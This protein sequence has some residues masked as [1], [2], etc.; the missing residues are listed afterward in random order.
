MDLE[1]QTLYDYLSHRYQILLPEF[2]SCSIEFL[3][4]IESGEKKALLLIATR[5]FYLPNV[6]FAPTKATD[7]HK[8]CVSNPLLKEYIQEN[9]I[10]NREFL[11]KIIA[12]LELETLLELNKLILQK[13][14][15]I[16]FIPLSINNEANQIKNELKINLID[17]TEVNNSNDTKKQEDDINDIK[18]ENILDIMEEI[19]RKMV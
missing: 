3:K 5:N 6:T 14:F 2:K 11:I 17:D 4:Q 10:P 9:R 8:H 7:L 16:I 13:K 19:E 15:Q 12:T 18:L 1:L